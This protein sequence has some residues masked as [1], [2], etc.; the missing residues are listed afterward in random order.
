M[1]TGDP[2]GGGSVSSVSIQADRAAPQAGGTTINWT[3]TPVGG[4]A[5]LQYKWL[6]WNGAWIPQGGWTTSSTFAWTP[7]F[8]NPYHQVGVWVRSAN[9]SVDQPEASDAEPYEI[10]GPGPTS[11]VTLSTS[12]TAPQPAN[13][14]I[15]LTA[16]PTGGVSPHQYKWLIHDGGSWTPVSGWSTSNTFVWTPATANPNHYVGVWVR[17]AG[18]NEDA[19]EASDSKPFPIQ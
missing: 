13:T 4:T 6:V 7:I 5:P 2:P 14:S 1:P 16:T 3:A 12:H 18:V 17:S 9:N 19:Y 10:T 8:G 11:S 15:T